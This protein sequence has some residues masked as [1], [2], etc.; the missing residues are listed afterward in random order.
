MDIIDNV[1]YAYINSRLTDA[2]NI[3]SDYLQPVIPAAPTNT[4]P[5]GTPDVFQYDPGDKFAFC[6]YSD[7]SVIEKSIQRHWYDIY[8]NAVY[9]GPGGNP[10]YSSFE[11]SST[12]H[13]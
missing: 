1:L 11:N 10:T 8:L 6:A 13:L 3:R 7:P 12:Y 2:S 4:S 9:N 5:A